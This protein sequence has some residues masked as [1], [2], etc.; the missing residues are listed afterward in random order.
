MGTKTTEIET[1]I[2]NKVKEYRINAGMS[3]RKLCLE[4]NSGPS[5]FFR[6]KAQV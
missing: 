3:Q 5:T 1:Y 2:I 6:A 4:L